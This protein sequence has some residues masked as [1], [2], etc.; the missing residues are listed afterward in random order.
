MAEIYHEL[1]GWLPLEKLLIALLLLLMIASLA[2]AFWYML[3]D[4]GSGTRT[5]KALTARI[6]IWFI[7]FVSIVVGIYTGWITPSNTIPIPP[8]SFLSQ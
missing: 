2:S 4:R 8:K 5:V 7:L 1:K 3:K 6:A